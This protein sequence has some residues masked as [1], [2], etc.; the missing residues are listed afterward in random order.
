MLAT[1][2]AFDDFARGIF[3]S[4]GDILV[5]PL[6]HLTDSEMRLV[7]GIPIVSEAQMAARAAPSA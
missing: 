5:D 7:N 2:D 3:A 6:F 4:N 1:D